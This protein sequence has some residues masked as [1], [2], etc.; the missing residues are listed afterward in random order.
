M[1]KKIVKAIVLYSLCIM[2]TAAIFSVA[3]PVLLDRIEKQEDAVRAHNCKN[4]GA[5]MNKF[6]GGDYCPK[7]E[8]KNDV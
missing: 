6:Y 7:I 5:A 4:Y 1:F 8:R 3:V 2:A